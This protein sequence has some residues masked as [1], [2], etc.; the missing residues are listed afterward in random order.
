MLPHAAAEPRPH[1]RHAGLRH[2]A[3]VLRTAVC[4]VREKS[5][6]IT[7]RGGGFRNQANNQQNPTKTCNFYIPL[8]LAI[9]S[10][11]LRR[12]HKFNPSSTHSEHRIKTIKESINN[13]FPRYKSV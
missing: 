9:D 11:I 3:A 4:L 13:G 6:N 10:T 2:R 12:T 7:R 8:C 5:Q 1:T